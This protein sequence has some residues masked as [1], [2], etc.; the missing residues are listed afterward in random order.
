MKVRLYFN[1]PAPQSH[2][3]VLACIPVGVTIT[4]WFVGVGISWYKVWEMFCHRYAFLGV[5]PSARLNASEVLRVS[6]L[7]PVYVKLH[8]C[9]C[10]ISSCEVAVQFISAFVLLHETYCP[11]CDNVQFWANPNPAMIR[12]KT[13]GHHTG[14]ETV[15]L[16]ACGIVH[17]LQVPYFR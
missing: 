3:A 9:V 13:N 12:R 4:E 2:D 7:A 5:T 11:S 8:I 15:I 10:V 14:F 1:A 17:L 16:S 6:G